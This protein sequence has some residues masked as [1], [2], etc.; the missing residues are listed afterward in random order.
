MVEERVSYRLLYVPPRWP[1]TPMGA[2]FLSDTY[3][4]PTGRVMKGK[5]KTF[6]DVILSHYI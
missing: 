2:R 6:N 4:L 3:D 5:E 1:N